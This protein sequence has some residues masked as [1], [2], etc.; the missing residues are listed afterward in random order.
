MSEN[1]FPNKK[2]Q[3]SVD[4]EERLDGLN[5]DRKLLFVGVTRTMKDLVVSYPVMI[6]DTRAQTK[7]SSLLGSLALL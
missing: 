7:A 5:T 2:L 4:P 1:Y 3:D 6:R